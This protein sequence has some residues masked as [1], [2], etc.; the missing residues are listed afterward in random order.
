[1]VQSGD[2]LGKLAPP[3]HPR[4]PHRQGNNA[5]ANI[6]V[7]ETLRLSNGNA[8]VFALT[9]SKTR[10][11]LVVTLDGQF[12]KRYRVST[13]EKRQDPRRHLQNRRQ[14]SPSPAGNKPGGK[15][16]PYGHPTTCSAPIGSTLDLPG[17]GLHGTMV[18]PIP[19]ANSPAPLRPPAQRRHRRATTPSCPKGT[20]VTITRIRDPVAAYTLPFENP[21]ARSPEPYRTNCVASPAKTRRRPAGRRRPRGRTGGD[22][23]QLYANLK[24]WQKGHCGPRH[25]PAP[26]HPRLPRGVREGFQ[27]TPR[28]TGCSPTTIHRRRHRLDRRAPRHGH[29]TQKGRDTKSNLALQLRCPFPEGVSRKALRLM[30]LAGQIRPADRLFHR[31]ARRRFPHRGR[32]TPRGRSTSPSIC[33]KCSASPVAH[34]R[35]RHRRRRSGGRAEA[36]AS[37]TASE[38]RTFLLFR[39]FR[40]KAARPFFENRSH[41]D[42]AAPPSSHGVDSHR[43]GHRRTKSF[44]NPS[45]APTPIPAPRPTFVRRRDPQESRPARQSSGRHS[46]SSALRQVP[47]HGHFQGKRA[48][49]P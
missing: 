34:S 10:N 25:P 24:P 6:R 11:D 32:R 16:I 39:P 27:R 38:P 20:L 18:S 1:M 30:R 21:A 15:A 17:Y 28:R 5:G 26:L 36:S 41:A 49:R 31:H 9:V 46:C 22:P 29:R 8:H 40:P 13:G 33:A 48:F 12:F 35:R 23:R 43:A 2:Y 45:A 44:P 19:S 47:R 7:G 37:P 14:E 3:T 42:T 4:R